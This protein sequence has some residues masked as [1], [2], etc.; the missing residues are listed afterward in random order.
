MPK[1][2]FT[3]TPT[4]AEGGPNHIFFEGTVHDLKPRSVRRWLEMEAAVLVDEDAAPWPK[5]TRSEAA[6]AQGATIRVTAGGYDSGTVSAWPSDADV[7]A[8][9]GPQGAPPVVAKENE[10]ASGG[11]LV[12]AV[13]PLETAL[14]EVVEAG[15]EAPPIIVPSVFGVGSVGDE[16][17][18]PVAAAGEGEPNRDAK[19]REMRPAGTSGRFHVY[20]DGIRISRQ[21][22][23]KMDAEAMVEHGI[24]A[25][26][27]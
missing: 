14:F 7:H 20:E 9:T 16:S 21:P 4:E 6:Q 11:V 10:G 12:G 2:R 13:V 22:L 5:H 25:V 24:D 27:R 18:E 19:R 26:G 8:A 23:A 1:I 15:G 17:G 3:R